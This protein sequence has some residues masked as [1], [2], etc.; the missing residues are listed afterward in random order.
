MDYCYRHPH[1][2]LYESG[3]HSVQKCPICEHER[4]MEEQT[5]R[6]AYFAEEQART[7]TER[8]E[9]EGTCS[10]CGQIFQEK[11]RRFPRVGEHWLGS[12]EEFR[13]EGVCPRCW[14]ERRDKGDVRKW[15]ADD[16]AAHL[17]A[18]L[19]DV[20]TEDAAAAISE[21][22]AELG[23]PEV[24][25]EADQRHLELSARRRL[26]TIDAAGDALELAD[27]LED[28]GLEELAAEAR[29]RAE[30]LEAEARRRAEVLEA[31]ARVR[32][33]ETAR[34]ALALRD[35]LRA[36][37]LDREAD[38]A[39]AR[40][41]ELARAEWR[42]GEWAQMLP[43]SDGEASE[44]AA[45]LREAG[46][47]EQADEAEA[48]WA[49][50][51]ERIERAALTATLLVELRVRDG[52]P[53]PDAVQ[54]DLFERLY[55]HACPPYAKAH[56]AR[57]YEGEGPRAR[58]APSEALDAV[59]LSEADM[60]SGLVRLLEASDDGA[61][62]FLAGSSAGRPSSFA[63]ARGRWL[64][65]LALAGYS[66][67]LAEA[68]RQR[69]AEG[70]E[71][72]GPEAS[73]RDRVHAVRLGFLM[74]EVERRRERRLGPPV[75]FGLRSDVERAVLAAVDALQ[76]AV[77]K[78]ATTTLRAD[79]EKAIGSDT[80]RY[81]DI[82]DC[83]ETLDAAATRFVERR[84]ASDFKAARA[85]GEAMQEGIRVMSAVLGV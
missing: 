76:A 70:I 40:R 73:P 47:L 49:N 3:P 61:A 37:G 35:E 54:R 25:A 80:E 66:A 10:H 1:Q 13:D 7:E 63:A 6:A 84:S 42:S 56:A 85:A 21:R 69:V 51:G 34:A 29:S 32:A 12:L 65:V 19:E 67:K 50:E 52:V 26:P 30:V 62:L 22:A 31:R 8:R 74:R 58:T 59:G 64:D 48:F 72:Q 5:S 24:E 16:W 9:S 15:S 17:R 75:R 33:A 18:E 23:L 82:V 55:G 41:V 68:I 4:E 46:L 43:E 39:E 27:E 2:R 77:P 57:P 44:H 36:R 14:V 78:T 28:G 79:C 60:T 38:D 71:A 45:E 20:E 11:T 81:E 83:A 53:V